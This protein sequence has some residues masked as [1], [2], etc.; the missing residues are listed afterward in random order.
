LS[1]DDRAGNRAEAVDAVGEDLESTFDQG[2]LVAL[3]R[4][5]DLTHA[6]GAPLV[7]RGVI[8]RQERRAL[9]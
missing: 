4:G 5:Q 1:V 3:E 7:V 2:S 8:V 9:R 6:P